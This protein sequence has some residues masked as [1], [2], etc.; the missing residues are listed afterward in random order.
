MVAKG[1]FGT[2]GVNDQSEDKDSI[3]GARF[4]LGAAPAAL[5]DVIEE[6]WGAEVKKKA[7]VSG[8]I[9]IKTS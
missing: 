7:L 3:R 6:F 1:A 9:I 5:A 4:A 8:I 2:Q